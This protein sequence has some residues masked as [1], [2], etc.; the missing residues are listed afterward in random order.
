MTVE[1]VERGGPR[2]ASGLSDLLACPAHHIPTP[3]PMTWGRL[4]P[5][6]LSLDSSSSPCAFRNPVTSLRTSYLPRKP[7][8]R[9]DSVF[10]ELNELPLSTLLE[11]RR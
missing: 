6:P 4:P 1:G 10:S 3:V 2:F 9:S 11:P 7:Q 5:P 8:F